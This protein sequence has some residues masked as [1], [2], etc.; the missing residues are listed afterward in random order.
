M[1]ILDEKVIEYVENL[2]RKWNECGIFSECVECCEN[3]HQFQ[4]WWYDEFLDKLPEDHD[5]YDEDMDGYYGIDKM[6][7]VEEFF[8]NDLEL[9]SKCIKF[10]HNHYTECGN[11]PEIRRYDPKDIMNDY[12]SIY[13]INNNELIKK[14]I[15]HRLLVDME[16]MMLKPNPV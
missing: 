8:G 12:F 11:P 4:K 3:F 13:V 16:K 10:V 1:E 9:F 15:P 5:D 14:Y 6:Y 7:S 2:Y